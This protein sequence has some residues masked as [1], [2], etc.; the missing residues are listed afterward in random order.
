M[1]SLKL[2]KSSTQLSQMSNLKE[3][4]GPFNPAQ[5]ITDSL[6]HQL[7]VGSSQG[8]TQKDN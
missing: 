5:A 3:N 6:Q 4:I 7:A 2:Y 8:S 1:E